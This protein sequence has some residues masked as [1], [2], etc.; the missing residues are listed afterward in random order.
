MDN[1]RYGLYDRSH[2][3]DVLKKSYVLCLILDFRKATICEVDSST[4]I[5]LATSQDFTI[6]KCWDAAS[7]G[8][9]LMNCDNPLHIHNTYIHIINHIKDSP[10]T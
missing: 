4:P 3:L 7:L 5:D 8:H 2:F 10:S 6:P 1:D 9:V